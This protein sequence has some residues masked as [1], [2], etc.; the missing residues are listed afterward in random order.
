M[1]TLIHALTI[2]AQTGETMTTILNSVGAAHAAA[3]ELATEI[4]AGAVDR[5]RSGE[6]PTEALRRVGESGLLGI[7]VPAE[8]GGPDMRHCSDLHTDFA[9]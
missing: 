5:E 2:H 8:F 7:L 1:T 3:A 6:L 4:A 9:H